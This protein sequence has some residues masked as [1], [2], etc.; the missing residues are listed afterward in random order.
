MRRLTSTGTALTDAD[1]HT[2]TYT[3]GT[4]GDDANELTEVLNA[5]GTVLVHNHYDG[6]G[7]V[8]QQDLADGTSFQFDYD[9]GSVVTETDRNGNLRVVTLNDAGYV[10][11]YSN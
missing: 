6:T 5:S 7:R 2:H 11:D 9:A 3:W 1:G 4:S 8:L 10:V